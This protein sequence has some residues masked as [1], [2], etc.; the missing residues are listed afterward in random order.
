MYYWIGSQFHNTGMKM[1]L[2]TTCIK[3]LKVCCF[4]VTIETVQAPPLC[5]WRQPQDTLPL[6]PICSNKETWR[7]LWCVCVCVCVCACACVCMCV[8][9]C[10]CV[11]VC[12][13]ACVRVCVCVCVRARVSVC[14]C[15]CECVCVCYE[16]LLL[17]PLGCP[18]H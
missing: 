7:G 6:W 18:G 4:S 10:A 1:G 16:E 5:T 15:V 17:L 14:V 9:V 13:C 3:L 8:C 2:S 11:R 12:V